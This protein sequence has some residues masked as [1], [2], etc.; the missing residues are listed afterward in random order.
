[1][2]YNYISTPMPTSEFIKLQKHFVVK[3]NTVVSQFQ[4]VELTSKFVPYLKY[5]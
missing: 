4:I 3:H 5:F 2:I 1:M